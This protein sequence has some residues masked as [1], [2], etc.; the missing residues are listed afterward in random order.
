LGEFFETTRHALQARY[1]I[2]REIGR[3]GT[4]VVYHARILPEGPEVAIKVLRPELALTLGAERFHREIAFLGRL[5]HPNIL[6]ILDS[7][8]DDGVLY[9]TMP[10]A[11]GDSLRTRIDSAGPL[12]IA[13][14][15]AVVGDV[16][17][18]IDHA[19]EHN[20]IH[21]DITPANVMLEE[22]R[23]IVCDFGIARAIEVAGGDELSSSGLVIGTPE[24]MSPEQA[25][26]D[27][28]L[29]GAVD[30]Y[31]LGC[32]A[33]SMLTGEAPFSGPT[34]QAVMARHLIEPPRSIRIVRPEV[35]ERM[36][37]AIT[38]ALAKQPSARPGSGAELAAELRST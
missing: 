23:A 25:S 30:I 33:Y 29:T 26:G 20:I 13:D 28:D 34:A 31:A 11:Q 19:H 38:K 2:E 1:A 12:A 8:E 17:A 18:A 7:G 10:L 22:N 9:F 35:P 36:E 14:A 37:R 16:A 21:R 24:Y 4:A 3:G 15:M 32:L 6:P 27:T 5:D